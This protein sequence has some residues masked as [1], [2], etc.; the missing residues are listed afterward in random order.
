MG[1]VILFVYSIFYVIFQ[2]II[3][4][5]LI[6]ISHHSCECPDGF[7]GPDCQQTKRSFE[8]GFAWFETLRQCEETHL[9]LEFITTS[10]DGTLIYNGPITSPVSEDDPLD[11]ILLEL[12]SG[13]PEL[14]INLGSGSVKLEIS[15][16]TP[17]NDGK[18]HK[19]DIFRTG[20]VIDIFKS[21]FSHHEPKVPDSTHHQQNT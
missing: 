20:Q 11:F 13:R 6:S 8:D 5:N 19:L 15:K 10:A 16:A 18:W 3:Y 17:L 9:S 2:P 21:N 14:T 4:L 1:L 7:E 12:I